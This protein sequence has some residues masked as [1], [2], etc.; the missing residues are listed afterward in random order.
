MT[1]K[2][3]ISALL[4]LTKESDKI[5]KQYHKKLKAL[6]E[7]RVLIQKQCKHKWKY[8]PDP[9]GNNDSEYVCEICNLYCRRPKELNL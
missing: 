6:S 4:K 7:K 1:I 3:T 9:S 8:L 2:E 5:E